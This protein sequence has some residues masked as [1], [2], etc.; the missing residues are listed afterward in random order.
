MFLIEGVVVP[1]VCAKI[2]YI[3][4][5]QFEEEP[6]YPLLEFEKRCVNKLPPSVV[7]HIFDGALPLKSNSS[8][9][10]I[11]YKVNVLRN[12]RR[13]KIGVFSTEDAIVN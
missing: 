12:R 2:D 5:H 11:T 1:T 8:V 13:R 10:C 7:Q 4:A 6:N 9:T 3:R